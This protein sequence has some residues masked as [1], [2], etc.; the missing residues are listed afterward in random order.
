MAVMMR[1]T[2]GEAEQSQHEQG[3]C[4]NGQ[5]GKG[6]ACDPGH[7]LSSAVVGENDKVSAEDVP[8]EVK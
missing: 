7:G 5:G 1:R 4:Q 3:Q 6:E 8:D 2:G